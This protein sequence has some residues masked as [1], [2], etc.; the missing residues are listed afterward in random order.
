VIRWG[1]GHSALLG[2][3]LAASLFHGHLLW[4]LTVTFVL[5]VAVGRSWG[6]VRALLRRGLHRW[7][8]IEGHGR[9]YRRPW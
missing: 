9:S 4:V 3:L 1:H 6:A 7:P 2:G 8:V 5:G